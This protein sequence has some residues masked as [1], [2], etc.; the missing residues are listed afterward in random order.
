VDCHTFE[1]LLGALLLGS[2]SGSER[3]ALETHAAD[4]PRCAELLSLATMELGEV[5]VPVPDGLAEAVL[6]RTSGSPCGRAREL[7]CDLTD[8][9]LDEGDTELIGIHLDGCA[10]CRSIAAAMIRLRE[11]LPLLAEVRPGERFL[12]SVLARTSRG[13]RWRAQDQLG[14]LLARPRLAAE[15]AYLGSLLFMVLVAMPGAPLHGVPG[16]ALQ[17]TRTELAGRAVSRAKPVADLR[18]RAEALE[19]GARLELNQASDALRKLRDR[20][21]RLIES[22][23]GERD[24]ADDET[25]NPAQ[26]GGTKERRP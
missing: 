15:G 25:T 16:M 13:W 6:E 19:A 24:R 2:L 4:C 18:A 8:G 10:E 7:L 14:R 17:A 1:D 9:I 22:L 12:E 26:E 23:R 21:D 11:D 20:A 3:L 5:E